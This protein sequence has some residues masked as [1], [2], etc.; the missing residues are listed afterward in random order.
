M[1]PAD[2][3]DGTGTLG[4]GAPSSGKWAQ[5][6]SKSQHTS[7]YILIEQSNRVSRDLYKLARNKFKWSKIE[8][9][10]Q[11]EQKAKTHSVMKRCDAVKFPLILLQMFMRC[12]KYRVTVRVAQRT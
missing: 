2:K 8:V 6:L 7:K 10:M 4:A 1:H 3:G 9:Q 5:P 11:L 12:C